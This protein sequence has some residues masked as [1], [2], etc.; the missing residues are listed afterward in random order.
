MK[1]YTRPYMEVTELEMADIIQTSGES[2]DNGGSEG[3]Y[4]NGGAQGVWAPVAPASTPKTCL[5][6]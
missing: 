2:L 6:D 5:V 4:V 1:K 3:D